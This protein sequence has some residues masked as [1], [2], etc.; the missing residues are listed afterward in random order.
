MW[1][2]GCVS[3]ILE[4]LCTNV[5]CIANHSKILQMHKTIISVIKITNSL[6]ILNK[7]LIG[8]NDHSFNNT[9]FS[10]RKYIE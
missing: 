3:V 5:M 9:L 6:I 10:L 7:Q 8:I 1:Q 4:F 2:T